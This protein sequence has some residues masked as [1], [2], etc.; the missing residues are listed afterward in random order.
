MARAR[1]FILM[2]IGLAL[3]LGAG[4]LG[5]QINRPLEPSAS[6]SVDSRIRQVRLPHKAVSRGEP[7]TLDVTLHN[8]MGELM[9]LTLSITY[10][11]GQKQTVVESSLSETGALSWTV[12]AD[13]APGGAAYR[14]TAGGCGCGMGDYGLAPPALESSAEGTFRVD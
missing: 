1:T 7:Q 5:T 6:P 3:I 14:L 12:P 13:T 10:A 4:Y 2:T 11:D 8:P 9:I